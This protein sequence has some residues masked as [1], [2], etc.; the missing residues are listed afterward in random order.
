[1]MAA[2]RPMTAAERPMTAL[3]AREVA[4]ATVGGALAAPHRR[5][6]PPSFIIHHG[7]AG[8]CIWHEVGC[9]PT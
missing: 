1:M 5:R 7:F 9:A 4:V 8:R 3:R 2:A 6:E